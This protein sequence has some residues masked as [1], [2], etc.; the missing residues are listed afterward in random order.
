MWVQW[1]VL[2]VLGFT[3]WPCWSATSP[4]CTN[5]AGPQDGQNRALLIII[6][7]KIFALGLCA[8]LPL[9]LFLISGLEKTLG[10]VAERLRTWALAPR[11][12]ALLLTIMSV[13]TAL[14]IVRHRPLGAGGAADHRRRKRLSPA[15]PDFAAGHLTLP[16]LPG[17]GTV[18]DRIFEEQHLPGEQR[19]IFGQ[20]PFGQSFILLPACWSAG[21]AD[22]AAAGAG[23]HRRTVS[24]GPALVLA[25]R[26][27][28]WR[29]C[30]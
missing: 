19:Q 4:T 2:L 10:P 22:A 17:R 14:A 5:T 11:R 3:C 27:V 15:K 24:V 21:P 7:E 18:R 8:M 25:R 1:S 30:C 12:P 13:F 28:C 16:S 6:N 20:Y 23:R 29:R 9:V 26:A